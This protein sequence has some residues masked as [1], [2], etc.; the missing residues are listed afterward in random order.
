[1]YVR[2]KWFSSGMLNDFNQVLNIRC[3]FLIIY[4]DSPCCGTGGDILVKLPSSAFVLVNAVLS[5]KNLSLIQLVSSN[6]ECR[7]LV[8]GEWGG[9]LPE[10]YWLEN[11][12]ELDN[13]SIYNILLWTF[14]TWELKWFHSFYIWNKSEFI[15]FKSCL[16]Y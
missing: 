11:S 6:K 2:S 1:M 12:T 5:K 16:D 9:I 15:L 14:F 8:L 10:A 3:I 7:L 4:L 13:E